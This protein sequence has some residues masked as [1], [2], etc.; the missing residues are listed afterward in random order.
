M[1]AKNGKYIF[2]E[3]GKHEEKGNLFIFSLDF[4]KFPLYWQRKSQN[5]TLYKKDLW[6]R[7]K[8]FLGIINIY[9]ISLAR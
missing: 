2:G 7:R 4:I 5:K 9:Y 6:Y 3:K 8:L 1:T